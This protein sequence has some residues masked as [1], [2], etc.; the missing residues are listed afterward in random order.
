MPLSLFTQC[1]YRSLDF[2]IRCMQNNLYCF[3][4]HLKEVL[5]CKEGQPVNLKITELSRGAQPAFPVGLAGIHLAR[6]NIF[7]HTLENVLQS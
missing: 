5:F 3:Q 7:S 4:S 2:D 6:N 1:R